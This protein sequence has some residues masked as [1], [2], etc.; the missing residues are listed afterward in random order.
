[1]LMLMVKQ[2]SHSIIQSAIEAKVTCDICGKQM[3]CLEGTAFKM[4]PT[5]S[6]SSS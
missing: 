5:I 4:R 3:H 2:L 6:V 1:M